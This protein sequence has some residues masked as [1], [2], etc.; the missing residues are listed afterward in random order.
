MNED[1]T[2]ALAAITAIC[3]IFLVPWLFQ[4]CWNFSMIYLFGLPEIT[5]WQSAALIF[6]M[7]I[8]FGKITK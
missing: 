8:L 5:Y 7:R 2:D 3:F 6:I 4:V 1:F